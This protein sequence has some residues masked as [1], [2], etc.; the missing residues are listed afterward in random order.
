M[1]A[2]HDQHSI[3]L[4]KAQ[5][6][7]ELA[8]YTHQQWNVARQSMERDDD[9]SQ[10]NPSGGSNSGSRL[11]PRDP[12]K[13]SR[14]RAQGQTNRPCMQI[15]ST[16]GMTSTPPQVSARAITPAKHIGLKVAL[17]RRDSYHGAF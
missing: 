13:S 6:S 12:G 9:K 11:A 5:Y 14:M 1:T 10:E 4:Q 17:S 3:E 15:R 2:M 7:R 8:A 16:D